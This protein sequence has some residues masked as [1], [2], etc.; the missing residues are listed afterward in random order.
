MAGKSRKNTKSLSRREH[1]GRRAAWLNYTNGGIAALFLLVSAAWLF[2]KLLL[3]WGGVGSAVCEMS[4]LGPLFLGAAVLAVFTWALVD[5]H[6]LGR[7]HE[8]RARGKQALLLRAKQVAVRPRIGYLQL[9]PH[10]RKH[11]HWHSGSVLAV[12]GG[13]VGFVAFYLDAPALA[14]ILLG[15]VFPLALVAY[16]SISVRRRS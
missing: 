11:F 5:L 9:P 3:C 14:A 1:C 12:F 15:I 8:R 7:E 13:F 10:C 4:Y 16:L 2:I 6:N